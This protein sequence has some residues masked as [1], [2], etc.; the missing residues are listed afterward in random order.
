MRR[1]WFQAGV[2]FANHG[3]LSFGSQLARLF[4]RLAMVVVYDFF[5]GV[6]C[7]CHS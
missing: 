1:N 3:G 5:R 2:S 4:A 7:V 6:D